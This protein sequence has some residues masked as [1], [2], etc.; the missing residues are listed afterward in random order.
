MS[1]PPVM[2][3]LRAILQRRLVRLV[4]RPPFAPAKTDAYTANRALSSDPNTILWSDV[5]DRTPAPLQF[6]N[7]RIPSLRMTGISETDCQRTVR[8]PN[9]TP[10]PD[11]IATE[12]KPNKSE[13][14]TTES[15][16]KQARDD[17]KTSPAETAKTE[18][19][20][21]AQVTVNAETPAA[22]EAV[23]TTPI[24]PSAQ[25]ASPAPTQPPVRTLD[26]VLLRS[27]FQRVRAADAEIQAGIDAVLR[28]QLEAAASTVEPSAPQ[29]EPVVQEVKEAAKEA[30]EAQEI[31]A[32]DARAAEEEIPLETNL[33]EKKEAANDNVVEA[34]EPSLTEVA[35]AVFSE[36]Q[37]ATPS[38]APAQK[39]LASATETTPVANLKTEATP[40]E[41]GSPE[42]TQEILLDASGPQVTASN[43]AS[44]AVSAS[45][46]EPE[47]VKPLEQKVK[48]DEAAESSVLDD[49]VSEFSAESK[50]STESESPVPS[51]GKDRFVHDVLKDIAAEAAAAEAASNVQSQDKWVDAV[52]KERMKASES[53]SKK[54]ELSKKAEKKKK[55][56]ATLESAVD[57]E[58]ARRNGEVVKAA[59]QA[60]AALKLNDEGPSRM[61]RNLQALYLQPLRRV[62]K[63]G[64]PSCD[65]QLRSYSL[66]P[67]ESFCD[68]ALRAA[69]Y[70][71]LP[72]YGP[73][74][75]PK[76][77][78]R[79]TVPKSSFIFKKSQENFERITRRRLIQI[80]DGHPQ[81]VQMWLAFLQKH[82]QAAVG[83][84]ANVW[85]FS[86]IGKSALLFLSFYLS[87][88]SCCVPF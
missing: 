49:T 72:A 31:A 37:T 43:V 76:I 87:L 28:L 1:A 55:K 62:A 22:P 10:K 8:P 13:A 80:R 26:G 12:G 9:Q 45:N 5:T 63:Y 65:L 24:A 56:V 23:A 71:G 57:R 77:V 4:S 3:P 86:S 17:A 25:T 69:Y 21:D 15:P 53:K 35:E 73:V 20:P 68:F 46:T 40:V 54:A 11:E 52:L 34:P 66:R 61:P 14:T 82:Q 42:V 7:V 70:C 2:R 74:P 33:L 38:Q 47:T 75:L 83:M 19:V 32:A 16:V 85:E 79:W 18:Q 88:L 36:T 44:P 67:L 50:S 48:P 6:L 51:H 39:P 81:T 78:E 41:I 58:L 60:E 64:V 29:A 84:K 27:A 30:Q 59:E